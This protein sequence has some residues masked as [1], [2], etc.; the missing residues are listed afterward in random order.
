MKIWQSLPRRAPVAWNPAPALQLRHQ[1][2]EC[3][4]WGW[5]PSWVSPEKLWFVA[6]TVGTVALLIRAHYRDTLHAARAVPL[7]RPS[8]FCGGNCGPERPST[9]STVAWLVAELVLGSTF[10]CCAPFEGAPGLLLHSAP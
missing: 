1:A 8:V 4:N 10:V 5:V 7:G 6:T 3:V 2:A 9:L